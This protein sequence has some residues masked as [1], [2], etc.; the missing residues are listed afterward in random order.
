MT[1]GVDKVDMK[2]H[3]FLLLFFSPVD[4]VVRREREKQGMLQDAS[5]AEK[6][7]L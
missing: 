4:L 5:S 6:I 2:L 1:E 3:C 7:S